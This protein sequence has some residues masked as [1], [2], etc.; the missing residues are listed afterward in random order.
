LSY[1]HG[2]DIFHKKTI[3]FE[4]LCIQA[5]K[6][7]ENYKYK[8]EIAFGDIILD[9]SKGTFSKDNIQ[10]ELTRKEFI[11]MQTLLTAPGVI[12]SRR[13][14][15]SKY[16]TRT[17]SEEKSVDVLVSRLRNKLGQ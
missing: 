3:D 9:P 4:I 10:I 13:E 8:P 1:L 6:L 2:A 17:D 7:I 15:L 11:L 16:I 14:I 5:R 12:F